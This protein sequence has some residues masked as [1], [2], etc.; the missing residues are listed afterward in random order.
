M[1]GGFRVGE[2]FAAGITTLDIVVIYVLLQVKG[3]R[4]ALVLW[5]TL[6]NIVFP[7]LGFLTGEFSTYLFSEWSTLL[8][9]VLLGLIGLHM[10]LY[11]DNE[12]SISTKIH[13][14]FLALIVSVDAFSVSVSFGMLHFNRLLFIT[15][16]G[17]YA[18]LF[19]IVALHFKHQLHIK[20]G[21]RLRQFAGVSLLVMGIFSCL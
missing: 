11:N 20:D 18:F 16:S 13:P 15:A 8:S 10:L 3:R 4:L 17:A 6:F 19:S 14:A 12:R 7:F 9:G 5:T 2:L 1:W 21:R